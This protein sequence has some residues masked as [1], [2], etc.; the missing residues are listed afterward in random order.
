M[1]NALTPALA[2]TSRTTLRR[3][4][5]LPIP[6]EILVREGDVVQGSHVVARAL[7]EGELRLVRAAELLGIPAED[8]A[9]ALKVR[10]DDDVTEGAVI[11][12]VRGLWGLFKSTV[13]APMSGRIEFVSSSTGHIGIRAPSRPLDLPAYITGTVVVVDPN[14]SVIIESECTFVQGIFGVGGE[15]QGRVRILSISPT[16][17]VTEEAI[18]SDISGSIVVGGHSPTIGAL[19]KAAALGAVGF[20]TGSLDDRALREYL[21][22]DIGVAL[23]GD[24]A[25]S[26]AVIIT[27]GFGSLPMSTRTFDTIKLVEGE[28]AS[29]NGAT[30]VRA[31]ALRPEFIA[32]RG[33]S[34]S[35]LPCHGRGLDVGERIRV[36]RVP[37]FGATG[38]ITELPHDLERIETGAHVRVL[39]AILDDGRQ[40]TVPRANV[41]LLQREAAST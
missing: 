35:A 10:I 21:G 13:L 20:I 16:T 33:S 30:Q 15:R 11:A 2:V 31:G 1:S 7:L 17:A 28:I 6:G 39:R 12:E 3:R 32:P 25:V 14:R 9:A 19:R 26:M 37:F 23:T 4:R 36:I 38:Q 34:A 40:V 18:P 8:V 24:E 29:I 5:D 22:Y 41:E 27:E